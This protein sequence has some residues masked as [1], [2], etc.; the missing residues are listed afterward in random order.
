MVRRPLKGDKGR[1]IG[2]R[3]ANERGLKSTEECADASTGVKLAHRVET[4]VV[5]ALVR[6][7]RVGLEARLHDAGQQ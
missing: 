4:A 3:C 6:V 7:E 2:E 1:G 5:L